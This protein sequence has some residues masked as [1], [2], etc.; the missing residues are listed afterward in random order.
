MFYFKFIAGTPYY[1]TENTEYRKFEERPTNS[2]LDEMAEEFEQ[3]NAE[4][5]EYF[6]TGWEE[7]NFDDE[8]EEAE[9][10]EIYYEDCYGI[11]EE[12]TKEEFKENS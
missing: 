6:V 11:W 2:E 12:I 9:A 7:N 4:S 1:G 8:D 5:Y 3:L 10:L